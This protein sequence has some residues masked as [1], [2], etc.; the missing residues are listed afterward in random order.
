MHIHKIV[1]DEVQHIIQKKKIREEWNY[2]K[3]QDADNCK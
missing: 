3:L 1:Y 2:E